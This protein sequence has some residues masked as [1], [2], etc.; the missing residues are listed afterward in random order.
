IACGL[1]KWCRIRVRSA[2]PN[3]VTDI[4]LLA[5]GASIITRIQTSLLPFAAR[6][7]EGAIKS[8]RPLLA[9]PAGTALTASEM[10]RH[11]VD[12]RVLRGIGALAAT[13]L[14]RSTGGAAAGA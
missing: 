9:I 2:S 14:A 11:G 7:A 6:R 5:L 8:P 3:T 12:G 10:L 13:T 1:M 4:D